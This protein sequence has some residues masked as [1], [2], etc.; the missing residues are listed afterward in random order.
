VFD[1]LKQAR[2]PCGILPDAICAENCAMYLDTKDSS[3]ER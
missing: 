1:V 2:L 3:R